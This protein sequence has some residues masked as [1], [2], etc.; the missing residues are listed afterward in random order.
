VLLAYILYGT[1][2]GTIITIAASFGKEE[3]KLSNETLVACTLV[4]QLVGFPTSF[5]YVALARKIG[6]RNAVFAGLAV[7]LGVT[8][9]AYFMPSER[10]GQFWL[11]GLL[12][13]L[14]QGGT[15]ALTR[16]LYGS[17]IP[18]GHFGEFFGFFSVFSKVGTFMGPLSFSVAHDLTG[19]ARAAVLFLAVFFLA[20]G[21]VLATVNVQAGRAALRARGLPAAEAM[22]P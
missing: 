9:F 5:A 10:A 2:I 3:L 11:M 17:M 7:Y 4:I 12:I 19:S 13:A 20:G 14:V 18:S 16:S 22:N 15:Q 8:V 6:A 21:A 1:G